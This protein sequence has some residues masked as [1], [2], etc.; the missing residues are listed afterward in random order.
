MEEVFAFL[1]D[2]ENDVKWRREWI[3]AEKTSE[4]P[5][6]V[7]TTFRLD[8][9]FFGRLVEVEYEVTEYEPNRRTAY[10]T[11]SGPLS[12]TFWRT[13]ENVDGG[14]QVTI[15]YEA[16]VNGLLKLAAPLIVMMGK[17]PLARELPE[18]KEMMESG[19]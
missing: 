14:T 18:L 8:A 19:T 1:A 3:D 13:F 6:G 7:G 5:L 10:K 4:G 2:L 17:R 15:R 16:E 9:K 12:L 11:L